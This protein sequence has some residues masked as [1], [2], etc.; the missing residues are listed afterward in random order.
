MIELKKVLFVASVYTHLSAFHKPFI[1]LFQNKGYEVH[2]IG[3]DSLGRKDELLSM[4]IVCHDIEFDR[5]PFS[6]KNLIALKKLDK[7]FKN[8]NYQMIH[9]HT[10]TAAFLTRYIASKHNQGKIL[11]TAHGFHFFDGAPLKN[12]LL[13]YPA[14][15]IAKKWT[16]G[17]LVMN[18]ED[19][20]LGKRLGFQE[21]KNIFRVHGVGVDL[22]EFNSR[23]NKV[24]KG[25][26]NELGV[27]EDA[28]VISCIAE[29]SSR[30]NQKFILDNWRRIT[31]NNSN[32]HLLLI[33]N[34]PDYE[35]IKSFI[36]EKKL[37]NVHLLGYR[38]DVPEI[39]AQSDIVTL[40]SKQEGL[41]RCLMEAMACGKPI[42]TT[43]VRGSR[44]LV[45]HDSTGIVVD[46]GNNEDLVNA[47]SKL[48]Q[49]EE[50][51]QVYGEAGKVKIQ[52]YS[53]DNV[54]KEMDKIY[55]NF[56]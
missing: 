55:S 41:P 9:V 46:L 54:L 40:V 20:K 28:L 4:G 39:I 3:S 26:L 49:N 51:R 17:L 18:E 47:F 2:A 37:T 10:P 30:K 33:G 43:N 44:D 6:K 14:E 25:F 52:D 19:Y 27:N 5:Q 13:F 23:V 29:L 38:R 34:G 7:L 36:F 8:I 42:I 45:E 35:K 50:V 56:L 22:T 53:L 48:L 32:V 16:D 31:L 15:K 1:N 11:Y 24:T 12:W 21:D